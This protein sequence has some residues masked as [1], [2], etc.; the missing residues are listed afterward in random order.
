VLPQLVQESMAIGQAWG[1][2]FGPKMAARILRRIKEESA[3]IGDNGSSAQGSRME[4]PRGPGLRRRRRWS[5]PIPTQ[6][7]HWQTT[8]C[9]MEL[10]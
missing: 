3:A 7:A 1:L 4:S 2:D 8:R 6:P 10:R 9:W 5:M